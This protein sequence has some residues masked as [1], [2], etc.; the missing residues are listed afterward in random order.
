MTQREREGRVRTVDINHSSF[1][2]LCK[3][4]TGSYPFTFVNF[5][6]VDRT[7]LGFNREKKRPQK[8]S[9]ARGF[10]F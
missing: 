2:F 8:T 10:P 7:G 4:D 6:P 3:V 5:D 9:K 1:G